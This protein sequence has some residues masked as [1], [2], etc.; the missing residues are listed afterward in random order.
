[1]ST[2]P[3][4]R[5]ASPAAAAADPEPESAPLSDP[6]VMR[7]LA[8][9]VRTALL[10]LL[11]VVDTITATQASEILGESPATCA[12][13]LRTLGK[14]GFATEA[15]GG[16]GRERPWTSSRRRIRISATAQTDRQAALAA[17]TLSRFWFEQWLE[18]AR[19]VFGGIPMAG[20]EEATGWTRQGVYL[21][22]EEAVAVMLEIRQI[23]ER[24]AGRQHDPA[25]RPS[26]A[27]PVEWSVFSAPMAEL[28]QFADTDS[29][30]DDHADL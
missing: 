14:Y 10:E 7:A 24:Y 16:R 1:M 8:H 9:P 6:K 26:G 12:F 2:E 27:L 4:Q 17:D 28:A 11:S 3:G 18:R 13:H 5:P 15:G 25:Q 23:L 19:L 29:A 21:T 30:P 22:A 20:W